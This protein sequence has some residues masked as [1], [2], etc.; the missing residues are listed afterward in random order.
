MSD[1]L[2]TPVAAKISHD[3]PETE[4]SES[5]GQYTVQHRTQEDLSYAR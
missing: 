3:Q 1:G 5:Y 2:K 4:S